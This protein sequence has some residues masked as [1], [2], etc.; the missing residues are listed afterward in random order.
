M[1]HVGLLLVVAS[2][3]VAASCAS[4]IG[5]PDVPDVGDSGIGD[6]S[7]S[8]SGSSA[9]PNSPDGSGSGS[10]SGSASG[11]GSS[12]GGGSSGPKG[13][14]GSSSS[15]G[16]GSSSSGGSSS[17]GASST[18]SSGVSM[19]PQCGSPTFTPNGGAVTV[20]SSVVIAPPQ[21]FPTTFPAGDAAIYYTTDS[22]I[23]T[24]AS[25]AYSGPIPINAAE[26]I[27]AIASYPGVCTDSTIA[28]ATFTVT[29]GTGSGSSGSSGSAS[30]SG[31]S[32]GGSSS[33]G[34]SGSTSMASCQTSGPGLSNCGAS[35]ESCCTSL[36][37][38][39]GTYDRTYT[40]AG[41]GATGLADPATVSTFRLDKYLVTVGRFRQFVA[42][43]N[44]GAGYTPPAGSGKHTHLN[45]GSGLNA[46][47]GGNEPG[48]VTADDV[49][50]A[51][52]NAKLAC[53]T[54]Q[55][56]TWTN[57]AGTQETLPIDCVNWY[58]A[59]AFCIWDG[60]FL[61]SEAEW[62]YAAAGGSQQR[63]YP[64]GSTDP[65]TSN[66]YAIYDDDYYPAHA[67]HF[68]PVGTAT[69]GAGLWGQLDLAGEV[70][71]WNLD[72]YAAYVDP[73][74]DCADTTAN[75]FRVLRGGYAIDI[76]YY[77]LPPYR[78]YVN[79]PTYRNFG[80]GF[81]CSRTP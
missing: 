76:A 56:Q 63:E 48:W 42:A 55:Y 49:N 21:G 41:T 4:L 7:G 29:Q 34:G 62:E 50:I 6:A 75:S 67:T 14:S 20:G 12:G 1:R 59:Y 54:P 78:S 45:G 17:G 11:S 77:L 65:G 39:G 60:G 3:L 43:W 28:L 52:T 35:G 30:G 68:A 36:S 27:H 79:V 24:H 74:T 10:G 38:T 64:W 33:S 72:W 5:F 37:V 15:S 40:N 8:G 19:L 9:G 44:G 61:P 26:A 13:P 71:E 47:G 69:L 23:P 46:T 18:S 57:T 32:S 2:P 31:A 70:W 51:P 66:Q 81:R 58:E 53:N 80:I 16:S 25:P 73:C 22:T